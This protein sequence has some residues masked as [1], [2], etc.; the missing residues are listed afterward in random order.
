METDVLVIGGGPAGLKA[1]TLLAARGART[2]LAYQGFLAGKL[3]TTAW[4]DD[5]PTPGAGVAGPELGARLSDAAVAAGVDLVAAE[6]LSLEAYSSSAVAVLAGGATIT[7]KAIVVATGS[8]NKSLPAV[9]AAHYEGKGLIGCASCDAVFYQGA[10]ALVVGGGQSGALDALHLARFASQVV[11]VEK[12]DALT[13]GPVLEEELRASA[14]VRVL[15]HTTLSALSGRGELAGATLVDA[16]GLPQQLAITGVAVQVGYAP[17]T[18]LLKG[19]VRLSGTGHVP[20]NRSLQTEEPAIFAI[21][22]CRVGSSRDV[23]GAVRDAG[24]ACEAIGQSLGL[25]PEKA[26]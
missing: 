6:V 18:G 15:T 21:G 24:L 20:V 22:D 17:A 23:A 25:P 14:N 3:P 8:R 5:F 9:D 2:S 19:V 12:G 7:A 13:C 26:D 16:S 10:S 4:I 1:A 11:L